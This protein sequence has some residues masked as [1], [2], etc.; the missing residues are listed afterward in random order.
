MLRSILENGSKIPANINMEYNRPI[1]QLSVY[2]VAFL[3]AILFWVECIVVSSIPLSD[4]IAK[5]IEGLQHGHIPQH[6][7]MKYIRTSLRSRSTNHLTFTG[8]Y[9]EDRLVN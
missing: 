1:I 8:W 7:Y 5:N 2:P 3:R 6:Q 9:N 4:L